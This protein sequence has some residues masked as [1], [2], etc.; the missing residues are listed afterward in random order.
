MTVSIRCIF[1]CILTLVVARTLRGAE[2][3]APSSAVEQQIDQAIERMIAESDDIDPK[4]DATVH[5]VFTRPHPMLGSLD[6]AEAAPALLDRLLR[7]NFTGNQLKDNYVRFHLMYVLLKAGPDELKKHRE[8]ISK[9]SQNLP[10]IPKLDSRQ[11]YVDDPQ[12]V[13]TKWREIHQRC[14]RWVGIPPFERWVDPPESFAY[15]T[16]RERRELEPLWEQAKQLKFRTIVDREAEE[17]NYRIGVIYHYLRLYEGEVLCARLASGDAG[18]LDDALSAIDRTVKSKPGVA[19]DYIAYVSL[20]YSDGYLAEVDH[21]RLKRF[22]NALKVLASSNTQWFNYQGRWRNLPEGAFH[23]VH[24]LESNRPMPKWSDENHPEPTS[25]AQSNPVDP[26]LLDLETINAAIDRAAY[27]ISRIPRPELF[28]TWESY[29]AIGLVPRTYPPDLIQAGH[30]PLSA[31]ALLSAGESHQSPWMLKLINWSMLHELPGTYDRAMRVQML[32]LLPRA[33][34]RDWY[35]RDIN[36]LLSAMTDQ[37]GFVPEVTGNDRPTGFGDNANA[38]YAIMALWSAERAGQEIPTEAWRRMDNYWR[39]AQA[40]PEK[41]GQSAGW[42]I[43]SFASLKEDEQAGDFT[44][45]VNGPMTAAG[46]MALSITER[47]L[48]RT[49]RSELPQQSMSKQFQAG[50][51]WLDENFALDPPDGDQDFYYYMWTIQNVGQATGYRTFNK[52]DWFRAATAK[53]LNDQNSSGLWSGPKGEKVSTSFALLYLYRAKGPLAICKVRWI[54]QADPK[55]RLAK[56]P[57]ESWDNRPSDLYNLTEYI[58]DAFETPTSWQIADLDQPVHELIETPIL[59]LS[60]DKP[61]AFNDAQVTALRDYIQAGGLLL[62]NP[63]G[64]AAIPVIN[65][66]KALAKSL[67]PDIEPRKV[68]P[69]GPIYSLF[70]KVPPALSMMEIHNGV[71][72]LVMIAERDLGKELQGGLDKERDAFN[73][74]A[75]VYLFV[76][77]REPRRPRLDTQYIVRRP[78]S[79]NAT[80]AAARL[81]LKGQSDAEPGAFQQL[82]NLLA[83][84][85]AVNLDY[86]DVFPAS[87]M[88]QKF[89]MLSA[90]PNSRISDDE[91][92][93]IAKWV[94]AGHTLWIDALGG[95]PESAARVREIVEKLGIAPDALQPLGDDDPIL[96]GAGLP[97][98]YDNRQAKLRIFVNAPRARSEAQIKSAA[99]GSG[100]VYVSTEDLASGLAGLNHWQIQ[101]YAP[102]FARQLIA[103]SVLQIV[104]K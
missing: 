42:A 44:T 7:K 1:C 66:M 103:N 48:A 74:L 96:T 77:G 63:E 37:G 11:Y 3:A 18:A 85:H 17:W 15:M 68:D 65:S 20:A 16:R 62:C 97:Q 82:S 50:V 89:A 78:N 2:P 57:P 100:T 95:S 8:S 55:H 13:G 104:G 60:T 43:R 76:S 86:D 39:M 79:T 91:A 101:G 22:A 29:V 98:G 93:A 94:T 35:G 45:R 87:L 30:Q 12:E 25:Q 52:I 33:E 80:V 70:Q 49:R 53:L 47:V 19:A 4:K 92:S 32:S 24:C 41:P 9:L 99:L 69:E 36:G 34:W 40:R 31:W 64:R 84:E 59:Y 54:P 21:D 90:S 67:Y 72:P 88:A 71:R 28:L 5:P 75:N 102:Q 46:V 38:Q 26:D 14:R 56:V 58:S 61:F 83:N 23:L 10:E 73:L 51:Q 6:P 27:G 81:L